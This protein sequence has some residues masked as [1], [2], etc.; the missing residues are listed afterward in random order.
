MIGLVPIIQNYNG[1]IT[2]WAH[3]LICNYP[4]WL[5]ASFCLRCSPC[6]AFY[7]PPSISCM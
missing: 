4:V 3:H 2:H 5:M 6:W 1:V 7:N